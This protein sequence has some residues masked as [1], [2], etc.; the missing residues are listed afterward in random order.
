MIKVAFRSATI[1]GVTLTIKEICALFELD[2]K[3]VG[4]SEIPT[5]NVNNT[6]E[7]EFLNGEKREKYVLQRINRTA[8][9]NPPEVME[10][11]VRV[12]EHIRNKCC[13][14]GDGNDVLEVFI[15]RKKEHYYIVD[16]HDE[17]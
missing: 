9:K 7:V 2:G 11:I 16:D 12:T 4:C 1:G 17:Y 14:K 15:A 13:G 3:Y 8:F 6:Y 5:G 10:N